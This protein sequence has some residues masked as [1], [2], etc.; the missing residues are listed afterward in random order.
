MLYIKN[1]KLYT[2]GLFNQLSF[3]NYAYNMK[4]YVNYKIVRL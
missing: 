2:K 3:V 4:Y 1:G